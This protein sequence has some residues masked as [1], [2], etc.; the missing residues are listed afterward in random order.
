M[1]TDPNEVPQDSGWLVFA[2]L[3]LA[4]AGA[5][6]LFKGLVAVTKP[7]FYVHHSVYVFSSFTAMGWTMLVLGALEVV[8]AFVIFMGS[9]IVRWFGVVAAALNAVGSLLFIHSYP[10][11]TLAILGIEGLVIYALAV[12]WTP[13]GTSSSTAAEAMADS[14]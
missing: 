12:R 5:F 6:N 14:H 10:V 7:D 8:A 3:M 1:A 2:S 4:I 13:T 11:V 9:E